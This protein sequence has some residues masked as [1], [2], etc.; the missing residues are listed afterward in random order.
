MP[1]YRNSYDYVVARAVA[2][3]YLLTKWS[4]DLLKPG[5]KLLTIKGGENLKNEIRMVNKQKFVKVL[6]IFEKNDNQI[7]SVEFNNSK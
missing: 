1:N 5:G 4:K 7:L 6:N 3:L 2:T